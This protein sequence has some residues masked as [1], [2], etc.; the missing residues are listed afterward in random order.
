MVIQ[1]FTNPK[2]FLLATFFYIVLHYSDPACEVK[3]MPSN[4]DRANTEAC[5][6]REMYTLCDWL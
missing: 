2:S 4:L 6:R 5:P 1:A 3:F